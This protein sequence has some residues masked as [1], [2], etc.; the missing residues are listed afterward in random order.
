MLKISAPFTVIKKICITTG[1]TLGQMKV[2]TLLHCILFI[3]FL[4]SGCTLKLTTDLSKMIGI[5][6]PEELMGSEEAQQIAT[7]IGEGMGTKIMEGEILAEDMGKGFG[8]VF[9]EPRTSV[10]ISDPVSVAIIEQSGVQHIQD[11]NYRLAID[12]FKRTNN[13]IR[14]EQIAL[15]LFDRGDTTAAADL[16]QY[17]ADRDWSIRPPYLVAKEIEEESLTTINSSFF[18][19]VDPEQYNSRY[20]Q[21]R[22]SFF[23]TTSLNEDYIVQHTV[24]KQEMLRKLQEVPVI[25]LADAYFVVKQHTCFLD[26]ITSLNQDSLSI[27]LEYQLLKLKDN[28]RAAETLNYSPLLSFIEENTIP[29][30]THGPEELKQSGSVIDFF[31]W[32]TALAEKTKELV[33]EGQQVVIIIGDT[34]ATPAHLPFLVETL[35][36][37]NPAVVV[38]NPLQVSIEEIL[39]EKVVCS[40]DLSSWGV[41]DQA[42]LS[43]KNDFY[44]N[45]EIPAQDFQNYVELF[46][47]KPLLDQEQD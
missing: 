30:F 28:K 2:H 17:L 41:S 32:D 27:G 34:H 20:N 18:K 14:L 9:I 35:T 42:V 6:S 26:I 37:I 3:L 45:T 29:V 24:S 39:E 44:L 36:G 16:H 38:Q 47:L 40:E 31:G 43:I 21:Q 10:I 25:I 22:Y 33:L 13:L 15:I 4:F 46:N 7:R 12:A 23:E 1:R 19:E 8:E 11:G 5:D